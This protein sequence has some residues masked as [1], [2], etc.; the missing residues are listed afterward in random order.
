[1]SGMACAVPAILACR[2][3]ENRKER[4]M[5]MLALP[6]MSC[7][8]R[9]PVYALLTAMLVPNIKLWG[10]FN[11]PGLVMLGLYLFGFFM[12]LAVIYFINIFLK[13]EDKNMFMLELPL[14]ECRLGKISC[15]RCIKNRMSL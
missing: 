4:I 14:I 10:I 5:T 15:I 13:T 6:L 12:T 7:S 1:M 3:I 2:N 8:A 11:L 9:L